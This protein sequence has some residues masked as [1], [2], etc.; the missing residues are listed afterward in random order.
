MHSWR[1]F[2]CTRRWTA[3]QTIANTMAK[4]GVFSRI[5]DIMLF[6]MIFL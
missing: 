5:I 2:N 6:Y 3:M 1:L 4:V